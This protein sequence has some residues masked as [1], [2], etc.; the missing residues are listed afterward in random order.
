MLIPNLKYFEFFFK[1]N[2]NQGSSVKNDIH[3]NNNA[4]NETFL[5]KI[6]LE[7]IRGRSDSTFHL[8]F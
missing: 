5:K 4:I 7:S 1:S 2:Y 6:K 8:L 3:I